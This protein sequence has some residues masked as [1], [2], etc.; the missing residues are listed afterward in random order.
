M[1][2]IKQRR[3]IANYLKVNGTFELMNAGFTDLNESPSAKTTSKRYIGDA[4]ET[5]SI[6]GYDWSTDYTTDQIRS[7]KV[8]DYICNIG[9]TQL[10]GADAETE[11]VMVDLDVASVATNEFRARKIKVAIEVK[12]F[13]E[14]DGEMSA[15]GSLLGQG[16]IVVGTFNTTTKVFTSGFTAGTLGLLTVSS[17]AGSS[18]GTTKATVTPVLTAG[19]TYKY[20][21]ASTVTAPSFNETLSAS[22]VTWNG[23]ADITA[24]TGNQ[25]LIVEVDTNNK[26]KKAGIATVTSMA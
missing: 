8:V 18:S 7:E 9:E 3:S 6:S 2:A 11:Y 4:S 21:V 25:I 5:K 13:K 16:D 24:T 19:N 10:T 14:K 22:Y 12:D 26:A 17:A 15:D 1:G 23:V 20:I